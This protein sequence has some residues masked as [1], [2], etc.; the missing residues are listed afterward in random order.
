MEYEMSPE[1]MEHARGAVAHVS[2]PQQLAA[3]MT[4]YQCKIY[5]ARL[6]QAS[7]SRHPNLHPRLSHVRRV[8]GYPQTQLQVR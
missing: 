1:I 2:E 3:G 8:P 5:R 6:N 7:E 4:T